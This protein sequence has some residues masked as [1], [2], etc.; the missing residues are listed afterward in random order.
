MDEMHWIG[1]ILM[2][3]HAFCRVRKK[4]SGSLGCRMMYIPARQLERDEDNS[5]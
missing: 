1:R 2:V 5:S 4:Y 3:Q